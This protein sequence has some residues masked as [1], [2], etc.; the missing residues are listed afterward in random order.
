MKLL[1]ICH[2]Q[3][4]K[5]GAY[6]RALNL[7]V[8][9]ARRGH[10]VTLMSIHPSER[11]GIVEREL[12]GLKVVESPDLLWGPGRTGWDPWDT[13]KRTLWI[14]K[15]KFDVIHTVDTRPAVSMP[16][17]LSRRASGAAWVAD[18]T[19]WWGRGGATT[20][21]EGRL[22]NMLIGP[23][24]QLFEEKPRPHAD[25]TVVISHALGKRAEGLGVDGAK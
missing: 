17:L 15:R 21:R 18:W 22:V 5:G 1:F 6:Y 2:N 11:F 8:P 10:D 24:E 7:G 14:R 3:T 23:L 19:D 13:L 4:R 16:A 20:E 12:D 9:L 25:G